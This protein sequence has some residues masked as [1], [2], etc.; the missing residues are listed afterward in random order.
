MPN[1]SRKKGVSLNSEVAFILNQGQP[2][3]SERVSNKTFVLFGNPRGGTTMIANVVRSMGIFLGDDL[4]V[5][6]EDNG[7][8]W[9]ILSR[10]EPQL[11]RK[12]KITSIK[13]VIEKRNAKHDVWGW[14]Y[15]RSSVYLKDISSELINPMLICVFRD[16]VASTARGVVRRREEPLDSIR[17]ALDLQSSNLR[18][19]EQ[20]N[21][22]TL[23]VSYEKAIADPLQLVTSLN[24]F[25]LLGL[26]PDQLATH[27][28][29]V[30]P[31]LGYSA[32]NVR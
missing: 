16:V 1:F 15:P 10:L 29:K 17:R 6:L 4:P 24:R 11:S 13:K 3:V 14:K 2:V 30:N 31:E 7:F 23:L 21:L 12:D 26:S 32:S 27:A 19:I 20:S 25:M 8:N 5:N 22:P 9:D 18:L 28:G